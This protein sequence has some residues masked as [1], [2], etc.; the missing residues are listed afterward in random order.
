MRNVAQGDRMESQMR[1]IFSGG[2][3]AGHVTPAI[4]IAEE[5]REDY[6]KNEILFIGRFS[7]EENKMITDSG[8]VLKTIN[9]CGIER[10]ITFN[11]VKNVTTAIKSLGEAK[12]IIQGFSP[13]VVMGTGGYVCWPV[14]KSAQKLKI[15]TVIHESNAI[16]GLAVKLLAPKCECIMLNLKGSENQFKKAKKIITVGNPVR[17]KFSSI[18]RENARKKLGIKDSEFLISSFGG[19]GGSK[20]INEA[21]ISLMKSHSSKTKNIKHI[22][23]SG[24]KYYNEIKTMYPDLTNGKYGC[25]IKPYI[26]DMS[27]VM[28]ASDIIISRCGAMTISEIASVGVASILIPSPN[29]TNN[30]QLKNAK[31]IAES[32]A[33]LMIE[34]KDL[35]EKSLLELVR[36]LEYDEALRMN[37]A[38]RIKEQYVPDSKLVITTELKKIAQRHSAS[39]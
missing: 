24:R 29:V 25:N 15:P 34:E 19:S 39:K 17:K 7:G 18:T 11:N 23:S 5:L 32:N 8:F 10:K 28:A 30:H 26:D 27:T 22:H 31:L 9:I 13:D 16:P 37:L 4:A 1:I 14:I 36:K 12:K 21:V 2:G 20:V 35:T 3:T 38:K 6:N 33:A